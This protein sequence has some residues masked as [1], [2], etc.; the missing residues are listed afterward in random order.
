M[1][2][3]SYRPAFAW[4]PASPE[5]VRLAGALRSS[6]LTLLYGSVDSSTTAL[7][8]EGLLPLLHRRASD[9]SVV[10]APGDAQVLMP[11]PERRGSAREQPCEIV[12]LLDGTG[13]APARRWRARINAALCAADVAPRVGAPTLARSLTTLGAQFNA[14]FLLV[15]D[16]F[17]AALTAPPN[18]DECDA[19][20]DEVL[21]IVASGA[22]AH[23]LLAVNGTPQSVAA[24]DAFAARLAAFDAE[25][26]RLAGPADTPCAAPRA[27]ALLAVAPAVAPSEPPCVGPN[28]FA[29]EPPATA[30]Q[31]GVPLPPAGPRR[32]LGRRVAIGV[33]LATGLALV[34]MAPFVLLPDAP[35]EV[36]PMRA[37]LATPAPVAAPALSRAGTPAVTPVLDLI[38]SGEADADRRLP[39]ELA[40]ALRA[41]GG[42]ELRVRPAANVLASLFEAPDAAPRRPRVAI[43]RYDALRA[44]HDRPLTIVAPLY[45]DEIRIAVRADSPLSFVHQLKGRRINIGPAGEAR[46]S[47]AATLY[48]RLFDAP[49]P[50]TADAG[51]DTRSALARLTGE[52]TLDAVVLV[53]P[54]RSAPSEAAQAERRGEIKWLR[55]D[56]QQPSSKRALQAFLPVLSGDGAALASI[57]FLVTAQT[58]RPADAE[59][60]TRLAESLCRSLPALQRDGDPKWR[61]VSAGLELPT[62]FPP[63]RATQAAWSACPRV[64][65][66]APLPTALPPVSKGPAQ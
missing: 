39:D 37:G 7:L 18:A 24:L 26:V 43:A 49:I 14:N 23:V 15:L 22:P 31:E 41:D 59:A 56:L 10:A 1:R 6:R 5:A 46:G 17:E 29:F 16:G 8:T 52:R 65:G 51:L 21:G 2:A 42:A 13:D 40:R 48:R 25:V 45:T 35:S 36:G 32:A 61:E 55:L 30:P 33:A 3:P 12:V 9:A 60:L 4:R 54:G 44:A 63:A 11:F 57:A 58:T 62:G 19:L 64:A 38:V 53:A 47:T 34:G 27:P 28:A 20:I 50:A 66:F